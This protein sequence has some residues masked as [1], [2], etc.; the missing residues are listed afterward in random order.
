MDDSDVHVLNLNQ[1]PCVVHYLEYFNKFLIGTYELFPSIEGARLKLPGALIHL[2]DEQLKIRLENINYR[3]GKLIL[4]TDI[5]FGKPLVEFDF[6]CDI[7]G[8][9]FD[10]K[11]RHDYINACCYIYVAHSNGIIGLYKLSLNCGNKIC[12]K[13]HVATAGS[14]MLTCIDI[15]PD[16]WTPET[17]QNQ[18]TP[19]MGS[20]S[21]SA[22]PSPTCDSDQLKLGQIIHAKASLQ[23]VKVVVGDSAGFV[24]I[25]K[26]GS[27]MRTNVG[28]GDSVW[29]VRALRLASD[30]DIILVGA[31]NSAWFIYGFRELSSDQEEL[32]LL[33]KNQ[34]KDFS[35]G[36]TSISILNTIKCVEYDLLEILLGSYDETLQMYHVKIHHEATSR[37]D[38]CHKHTLSINQGGIWR[39][40]QMKSKSLNGSWKLCIA[41]MYA[42]SYIIGLD[43]FIGSVYRVRR[44]STEDKSEKISPLID[45]NLL[46]L[47]ERPLHYDI[48]VTSSGT[49]F[50]IAD[51]NNSLCLIKTT[52]G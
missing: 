39:V 31:E 34:S 2:D 29:Q 26:R 12:L 46:K 7:G 40:K 24:T 48:D 22:S 42:G 14:K 1:R 35:A 36:V 11:V 51:F 16:N 50:C 13:E 44:D 5:D 49:T 19:P 18:M 3:A 15:F 9:V 47:S 8:G 37:P 41:A 10:I 38:V 17:Y 45:L 43:S 4:L 21:P 23:N 52:S 6:D 25:I 20:R 27:Q 33:Y 30:R 28:Q 32:V